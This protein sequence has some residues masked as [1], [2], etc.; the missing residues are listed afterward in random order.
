MKEFLQKININNGRV[1]D[2]FTSLY[3]F[4]KIS[5]E[6]KPDYDSARITHLFFDLDHDNAIYNTRKLDEYLKSEDIIH[7]INFS[8]GGFHVF[9][10]VAY[11]NF[12]QSKRDSI[13]N[14]VSDIAEKANL[15]V[16]INSDSDIDAHTIGNLAQLVRVP[17]TYNVKRKRFCIPITNKQLYMEL[18]SILSLAK[19]Q[20]FKPPS[21][22]GSKFVDLTE[23]DREVSQ[24]FRLPSI[25]TGESMGIENI[26]ISKFPICIQKLLTEKYLRNHRHRFILINYCRELGLP[27]KDVILLL[28]KYFDLKT[29]Q[30]CVY[31]ERQPMFVYQR[32]ELQPLSCEKLKKEGLCVEGCPKKT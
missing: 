4:D 16:G 9:V 19:K 27:L 26:D 17:N 10:P 8:G 29:F 1:K 3:S 20:N 21:L 25:E 32:A 12:L 18:N 23:Y 31:E 14:A 24:K 22:C 6:G 15:T 13:F 5:S 2:V 7:L 11:P 30:H 28:K